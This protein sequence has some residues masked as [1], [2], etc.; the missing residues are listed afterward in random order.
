MK[1][2]DALD[3][4]VD[5]SRTIAAADRIATDMASL[6]TGRLRMCDTWVLADL[7]R[8]LRDFNIQTQQWKP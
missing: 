5:A 4:I 8:E 7:K 1:W 2:T 3:A 6:I